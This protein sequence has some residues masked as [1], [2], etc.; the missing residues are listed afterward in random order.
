[1][2]TCYYFCWKCGDTHYMNWNETP[3]ENGVQR[4]RTWCEW[5]RHNLAIGGCAET[6]IYRFGIHWRKILKGVRSSQCMVETI[7]E[8]EW[9]E[10]FTI[11]LWQRTLQREMRQALITIIA[12]ETNK[13][14]IKSLNILVFIFITSMFLTINISHGIEK[15]VFFVVYITMYFLS[16]RR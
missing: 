1:M 16:S 9:W 13:K 6:S 4:R 11:I 12:P 15:N 14:G 8:R 7:G 5:P 3:Y 2:F 10:H